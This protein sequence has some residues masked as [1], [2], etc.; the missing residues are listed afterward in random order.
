MPVLYTEPQD[1]SQYAQLGTTDGGFLWLDLES[2]FHPYIIYSQESIDAL[3]PELKEFILRWR[4]IARKAKE[5]FEPYCPEKYAGNRFIYKDTFYKIPGMP[6]ISNELYAHVSTGM[7]EELK[8]M[9]CPFVDYTG[10]ID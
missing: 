2:W 4:E 8:Q 5:T 7:E 10:S 9:G 3:A 1:K 6:G